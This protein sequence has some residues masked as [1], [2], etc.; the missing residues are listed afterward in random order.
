[1]P[2]SAKHSYVR[3][4]GFRLH[5]D[6]DRIVSNSEIDWVEFCSHV[7]LLGVRT[8]VYMSLYLASMLLKTDIPFS[9]LDRLQPRFT[10]RIFLIKKMLEGVGYFNPN[11]TKFSNMSY[12]MFVCLHFESPWQLIDAVKEATKSG[13]QRNLATLISSLYRLGFKRSL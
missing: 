11:Q 7:E 6:V 4:P 9:A 1:M 10:L 5:A 2:S 13:R 8:P 3:A 12:I